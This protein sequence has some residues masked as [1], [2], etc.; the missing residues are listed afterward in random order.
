M[1]GGGLVYPAYD[2]NHSY[3]DC[4][5][6][7]SLAKLKEHYSAGVT[8]SMKNCFGITPCTIYGDA[9]PVDEPSLVLIGGREPFHWANRAPAKSALPELHSDTPR[10][11]GYRLL[12][13][14]AEICAA[15][16]LHLTTIDG[17]E[18]QAGGEDPWVRGARA[19]RNRA[20]RA[21][22]SS[23]STRP[24]SGCAIS[25]RW[26]GTFA[27]SGSQLPTARRGPF[28]VWR[29]VNADIIH[30]TTDCFHP[31]RIVKRSDPAQRSMA[32]LVKTVRA[33]RFAAINARRLQ[34][35]RRSRNSGMVVDFAS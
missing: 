19:G 33:R 6:F 14:V 29:A 18:T 17:I 32:F 16:P 3:E 23:Y 11:D 24:S 9:A 2:L 22:R 21:W 4:D 8:L 1:P 27:T 5:V 35:K 13:I 26:L 12:R 31:K 10:N 7:V 15:R 30:I 28:I 20:R 34:P 25:S